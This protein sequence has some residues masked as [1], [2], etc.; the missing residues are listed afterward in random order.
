MNKKYGITKW[1]IACRRGRRRNNIQ[2]AWNSSFKAFHEFGLFY[3]IVCIALKTSN[4]VHLT[5]YF[6]V[7]G[8]EPCCV[9]F[10]LFGTCTKV[11]Q[12]GLYRMLLSKLYETKIIPLMITNY[13]HKYW[14]R[15]WNVFTTMIWNVS[16]YNMARYDDLLKSSYFTIIEVKD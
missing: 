6:V 4:I 3:T 1:S 16:P 13:I 12:W 14:N 11:Y 9:V 15:N 8:H 10:V 5:I 7:Y 2:F